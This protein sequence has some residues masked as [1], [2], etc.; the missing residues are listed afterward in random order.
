MDVAKALY[1]GRH[2]RQNDAECW[3]LE[4]TPAAWRLK[5]SDGRFEFAKS[6]SVAEERN[7]SSAEDQF[8][9]V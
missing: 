8:Q 3:T 9:R 6:S 4:V 1:S 2:A 5:Q 7:I